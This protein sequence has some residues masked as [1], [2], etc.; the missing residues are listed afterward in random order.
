MAQSPNLINITILG[1]IDEVGGNTILLE[2]K[3]YNVTTVSNG[4]EAQER[5]SQEHFH[6]AFLDVH[7]PIMNGVQTLR[8][9]KEA[10]AKTAI[11][12]M[13]SFPDALLDQAEQEGAISCIHKP[14]DIKEV[15]QVISKIAKNNDT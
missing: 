12:M 2:D 6:V 5:V 11:V 8:A 4:K 13:D 9:I 15:M 14:F 7:M 3:G 1:G 10:S